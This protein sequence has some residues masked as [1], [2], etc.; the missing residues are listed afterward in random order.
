MLCWKEE[1]EDAGRDAALEVLD[2]RRAH[3]QAEGRRLS[4]HL[5]LR[6]LGLGD[7]GGR[8]RSM[9]LVLQCLGLGDGVLGL[10]VLDGG[11]GG[12][13][14]RRRAR[15][16]RRRES[17]V[18]G[19]CRRRTRGRMEGLRRITPHFLQYLALVGGGEGPGKGEKE[20]C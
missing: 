7:G 1:E 11:G 8:R 5:L 6:C 15:G 9:P 13:R 4:T 2:Q 12:R 3:G 10:F 18:R 16:S 20:T 19:L 14:T 17:Q